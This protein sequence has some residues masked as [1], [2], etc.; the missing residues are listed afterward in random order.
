MSAKLR[1]EK[2]LKWYQEHEMG[3]Q[4]G[5]E[6]MR[7]QDWRW[8]VN[9]LSKGI[10]SQE[11]TPNPLGEEPET[12]AQV[13]ERGVKVLHEIG[14][15]FEGKT[16]IAVTSG[17]IL[18]TLATKLN[19]VESNSTEEF[20]VYFGQSGNLYPKPCSIVHF[21]RANGALYFK[22]KEDLLDSSKKI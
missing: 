5:A 2:C 10:I 20:P 1:N 22:G 7:A 18:W 3:Q 19:A 8:Q 16:V 9:P 4:S 14:E 21:K 15:R 17:A 13:Y 6:G 11:D 12:I